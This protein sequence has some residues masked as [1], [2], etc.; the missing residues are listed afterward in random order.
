[1][2]ISCPA[3]GTGFNLPEK[4][5][6]PKGAKLRCSKC[7]HVFR[8]RSGSG[9]E[10]EIFYKPEDEAANA[11]AN[12]VPEPA[13][14][15]FGRHNDDDDDDDHV[16]AIGG[17]TRMGLGDAHVQA[18]GSTKLGVGLPEISSPHQRTMFGPAAHA[19]KQDQDD[20]DPG[21]VEL[22]P[23]LDPRRGSS[24]Q[25]APGRAATREGS[26]PRLP[27]LGKL[28]ASLDQVGSQTVGVGKPALD[29]PG[30][31]MEWRTK[32]DGA[33]LDL[34][35]GDDDAHEEAGADAFAG[36]FD[37]SSAP[38]LGNK[39]SSVAI[40]ELL[41]ANRPA[42]IE[43]DSRED[44]IL[45]PGQP[46]G[47]HRSLSRDE[48]SSPSAS[49]E[50]SIA[51][52]S[53][54]A[55]AV[56][57]DDV[58]EPSQ[59]PSGAFWDAGVGGGISAADL[60]DPSFGVDGPA[61]DS[62]RGVIEPTAPPER[63]AAVNKPSNKAADPAPK[64]QLDRPRDTGPQ[65]AAP[66]P[67]RASGANPA[68]GAPAAAQAVA[69]Y[70]IGGS[71]PQKVANMALIGLSVLVAFLGVVAV[72]NDMFID[73]KR[74]GHMLEVGF[75]GEPFVP[76]P[77]WLEA[78]A[79]E[80]KAAEP[81]KDAPT[82]TPAPAKAE[83]LVVHSVWAEVVPWTKKKSVLVV[84]GQIKNEDLQDYVEVQLRG[85]VLDAQGQELASAEAPAGA[86]ISSADMK[87]LGPA[88]PVSELL[89]A[90][91]AKLKTRSETPFT[92]LFEEPP[93]EV[94]SGSPV[95]YRVE[96]TKRLGEKDLNP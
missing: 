45:R 56:L 83:R 37:V 43:R 5:I 38:G 48:L 27:S 28:G 73:F 52:A 9:E 94:A 57:P 61:F 17:S 87:K 84:R 77:E 75:G 68:L 12:P 8:V 7:A 26:N 58:P 2:V 30:Q 95:L 62:T 4:H 23:L 74:F 53:P 89:P 15:S 70:Q 44:N 10:P 96:I 65:R 64:L 47:G 31:T 90:K 24:T 54:R 78:K 11:A 50:P 91:S 63:P 1:M 51:P 66:N 32:N 33:G 59:E 60:V 14:P 88:K 22:G 92:I 82:P 81:A 46:S 42:P 85:V 36:A 93:S 35:G 3:C 79:A 21:T 18:G 76:R 80:P 86:L 55:A 67:A 13:A 40:D 72:A 6:T 39:R 34:F 29:G 25:F 69:P 71:G 41:D 19:A 49:S 20:E 16:R